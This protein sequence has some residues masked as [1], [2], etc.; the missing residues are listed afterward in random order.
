MA[1]ASSVRLEEYLSNPAFAKCEYADGEAIAKPMGNKSH[2]R[3][4]VRFAAAL[5]AYARPR[6]LYVG[7][8]MHS[9]MFR[10]GEVVFR[11][12]D[13]GMG[14]END[15]D[16]KGH[17]L[18]APLLVVEIGSPDDRPKELLGKAREYF[19][20]GCQAVWLVDPDDKTVMVLTLHET[21]WIVEAHEILS[22]APAFPELEV[23]LR[24]VFQGV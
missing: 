14:Q 22:G 2:N 10:E 16:A 3:L 19:D 24:D 18:G 1:V 7:T 9:R 23:D 4:Q 6:G 8:E 11:L 15:F 12:P 13:I 17:Y 20:N 21:P 5:D